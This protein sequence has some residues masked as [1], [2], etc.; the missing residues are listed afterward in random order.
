ME[1]VG[2]DAVHSHLPCGIELGVRPLPGRHVVALEIRVLSGLGDEPQEK[3]GLAGVLQDTISKGTEKRD[4]R[5]LL[6]AFDAIGA[7]RGGTL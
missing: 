4:A 6:D 3:L 5:A 2:V 1:K 7:A